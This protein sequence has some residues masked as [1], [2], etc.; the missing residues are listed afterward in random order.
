MASTTGWNSSTELGAAGTDQSSNNNCGFNAF[1]EGGRLNDGSFSNEGNNAIFWSSTESNADGA[2]GLGLNGNYFPLSTG[3]GLKQQGFSVRFV[4]GNHPDNIDNDNDGYTENQG[5]CDDDN[6]SV[7]PGAEDLTD[8]IDNNCDGIVDNQIDEISN[9]LTGAS[10]VDDIGSSQTWYWQSDKYLHIGLGPVTDDYGG[11]EFA[12]PNWW[13]SIQPNDPEKSCMYTN[14]FV[15]TNTANG[16]TFEQTVGPAYIPGAYADVI[17]VT[18]D[19]CHDETVVTTMFGIKNVAFSP[20]TSKAAVEGSYGDVPY[21]MTSFQLSEGGFMGWYIG[22]TVYDIISISATELHVRFIQEGG[23]FA[24]YA[25][26]QTEKPIAH[27]DIDDDNDGFTENEGDCDDTDASINPA[28]TE[29]I[30]GIDND[31]DGEIDE[32]F[33]VCDP[34]TTESYSASN[35]NMT[36]QSDPS[37]DFI[38]DGANFSWVDNPDFDNAVNTSCK[39]GKVVKANIN[40]WDY[41]QYDLDA[42]LDF[43]A[44][45]GLKIKVWS[46]RPNTEVRLKLEEIGNAG[47]Y[48]DKFF[49]TSVTS[50]WEELTFPF[51]AADSGKFNKIVIFFDLGANNTDTYYF[52][53]LKLYGDG[54]VGNCPVVP[55]GE[56]LA[57]GDF[58]AGNVGCWQLFDGVTISTTVSNGGTQS[59]ELQGSTGVAVEL[60]MER[61][62]VGLVQ[63]NT[64]YTVQFDII[65]SDGLGEG[66]VVKAYTFSEGPNGGNVAATK[67]TLTDNTTSI[68]TTSWETKIFTFTTP[69]NANQVEGGLSFLIEIVNSAA[70]LNVDNVSVRLTP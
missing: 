16:L 30:D 31:C 1:P 54:G 47:N 32:G 65:A 43:V 4:K 67:H 38:S 22:E 52:D 70:R 3:K 48:I 10:T 41:N 35:L 9:L 29:I 53:D 5:D 59:A 15:F 18:G 21:T 37:E 8:G 33:L 60:R 61:F 62:G 68:S 12:W 34:E 23:E 46:A 50:G 20:S 36:F 64:S 39:V 58:E 66:G 57:N 56:L 19:I 51:S 55:A 13:N 63:P 24:W 25:K 17:G 49:T 11:G 40:P 42:K 26:Y 7:S 14:E 44:N 28:A 6:A 45:T 69:V 2:W 27:L